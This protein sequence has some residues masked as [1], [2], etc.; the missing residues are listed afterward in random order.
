MGRSRQFDRDAAIDTVMNQIWRLGYE[1]CSVKSISENLG[2]T[3][4]SF[5]NTFGS[6]EALFTEAL[7][8]YFQSSPD[9]RLSTFSETN[10]PLTLLSDVFKEA[11]RARASDP[12]HR[13]CMV[14][15]SVSE[16][17]G[18][19]EPLGSLLEDVIEQSIKS[20]ERLLTHSMNLGELPPTCN[21][22]ELALAIQNLLIGLNTLSKVVTSEEQLWGTAKITLKALGVYRTNSS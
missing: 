17:V 11:C 13:G 4:S 8:R 12:E 19:N 9:R 6:R 20:F 5:Y 7:Q 22:R 10:S 18:I 3:R 16:L 1:A 21:I 15:N 14:V 2:I